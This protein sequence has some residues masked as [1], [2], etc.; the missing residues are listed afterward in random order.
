MCSF[1]SDIYCV[2]L[3]VIKLF[4]TVRMDSKNATKRWYIGTKSKTIDSILLNICPPCEITR[5]PQSL[6]NIKLWKALEF[7]NFLLYYSLPCLKDLLPVL[8][9][10]Y[11]F[12]L[13]YA[14]Q[15]F[16][17]DE[18]STHQYD[19][20]TR[21]I[22]AFVTDI[23]RLYGDEFMKYNVHLLLHILDSVRNF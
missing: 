3:G 16:D 21:A 2:L 22:R 7:K 15:I 14:M 19:S 5:T 10:N 12:L 8:Y 23:E 13:V 9:L 1:R 17:S 6:D 20:A 4:L 18:I 11:W